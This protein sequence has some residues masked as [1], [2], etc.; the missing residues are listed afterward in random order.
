MKKITLLAFLFVF[1]SCV[2]NSPYFGGSSSFKDYYNVVAQDISIKLPGFKT[3][4]F[5]PGAR[6]VHF[7]MYHIPPNGLN[8]NDQQTFESIAKSQ[9]QLLRTIIYYAKR[10][11]YV[12]DESV[13]SDRMNPNLMN[14][15]KQGHA[16]GSYVRS[17]NQ[18][19]FFDERYREALNL[20]GK[21]IPKYYDFLTPTQKRY[22][23]DTGAPFTLFY[24]GILPRIYKS[25]SDKD[26]D[27]VK[28]QIKSPTGTLDTKNPANHYW[29]Y[30][31]REAKLKEEVL[32]LYNKNQAYQQNS[33]ASAALILIAYG[34]AH[35][36]SDEFVGY[37]FQSNKDFC[38]RW[39]ND[40]ILRPNPPQQNPPQNPPPVPQ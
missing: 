28:N 34:S 13:A 5:N 33:T 39:D 17:D 23:V 10:G 36:F 9:F 19:F 3:C 25:I 16:P 31:F 7:P 20:F 37:P 35:D 11:V 4:V 30:S 1:T 27:I 2:Y 15:L 12:F 8:P 14:F 29:V 21:G 22:L 26:L 32:N 6:I 38:L 18:R 24:L 40:Q